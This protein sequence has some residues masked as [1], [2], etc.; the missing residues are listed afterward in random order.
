MYKKCYSDL[1][2][3]VDLLLVD[4]STLR[5]TRAELATLYSDLLSQDPTVLDY[6]ESRI[7]G[8]ASTPSGGEEGSSDWA[9][10]A[11]ADILDDPSALKL[12]WRA[13][14]KVE[15]ALVESRK[16]A[17]ASTKQ[18]K[19]KSGRGVGDEEKNGSAEK[20]GIKKAVPGP[21]L[22]ATKVLLDDYLEAVEKSLE[23]RD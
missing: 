18:R 12:D 11:D 16:R 7:E 23:R 6:I 1:E 22:R 15:K 10:F 14:A 5:I 4:C 21:R 9:W 13:A 8:G 3:R 20:G 2:L 19:G 17:R